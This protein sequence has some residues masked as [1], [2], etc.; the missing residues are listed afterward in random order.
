MSWKCRYLNND[1]NV[2]LYKRRSRA[3]FSQ[4]VRRVALRLNLEVER[5][6]EENFVGDRDF[7]SGYLQQFGREED[8]M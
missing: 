4:F 3:N 1:L 2:K 7:V 6:N 8:H 5:E